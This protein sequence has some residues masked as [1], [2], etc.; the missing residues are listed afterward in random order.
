MVSHHL[1]HLVAS[2]SY[3]FYR[4]ST[5]DH[6]WTTGPIL[7]TKFG[8]PDQNFRYRPLHV[9][10]LRDQVRKVRVTRTLYGK[11]IRF[12]CSQEVNTN[13]RYLRKGYLMLYESLRFHQ[14]PFIR[15]EGIGHCST[16]C[17]FF[18]GCAKLRTPRRTL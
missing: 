8:P 7:A 14:N 10:I 13:L 5:P 18:W 12:L 16:P 11:C 1:R 4:Y 17:K 2:Y 6:F 9:T 15:C 3:K